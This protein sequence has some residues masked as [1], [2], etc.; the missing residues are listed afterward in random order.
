MKRTAAIVL[1]ALGILVAVA[2]PASAGTRV[3]SHPDGTRV[4]SS[5]DG[6]RVG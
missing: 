5:V 1:V 4:G 2:Q 3:G 6:T